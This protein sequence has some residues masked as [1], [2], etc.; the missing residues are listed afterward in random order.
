MIDVMTCCR[1]EP[2]WVLMSMQ[3]HLESS[4][5]EVSMLDDDWEWGGFSES[6]VHEDSLAKC[7]VGL[8]Y[9]ITLPLT[10]S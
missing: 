8:V 2:V 7:G 5:L 3:F 4:Q 6:R 9:P 10:K 1:S